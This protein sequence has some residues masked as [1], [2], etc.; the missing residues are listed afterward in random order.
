[1][2]FDGFVFRNLYSYGPEFDFFYG[3]FR[4]IFGSMFKQLSSREI[5]LQELA[6][7]WAILEV[8]CIF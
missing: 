3:Q 1:M 4:F 2:I 8:F 5:A 7:C 6:I